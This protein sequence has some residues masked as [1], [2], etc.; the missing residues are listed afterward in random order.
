MVTVRVDHEG[1][2]ISDR[3]EKIR[4]VQQLNLI[5]G[6]DERQNAKRDIAEA[7]T[8]QFAT[9]AQ[10]MMILESRGYVLREA[11]GKFK[12]I[13][14][15]KEL[16]EI[17]VNLAEEKLSGDRQN[18]ERIAQLK[19]LFYKYAASHSTGL[20][21]SRNGFTSDFA[22]ALK[23]KF[24]I[25]LLFHASSDKPVYG[26][27]IIDHSGKQVLKGSQVIPLMELL[28][29]QCN[30]VIDEGI[31]AGDTSADMMGNP[32]EEQIAYYHALLKA[33][34]YNYPDFIQGLHHQGLTIFRNGENFSLHDPGM[35]TSVPLEDV[36]GEKEYHLVMRHFTESEESREAYH[37]R[38]HLREFNLASD[39]DDEAIHGRNR[40]RVK[41]ART[42]SR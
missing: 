22:I 40:R 11:D 16:S 37:H 33:A 17:Q 32:G 14:F 36:A 6:I 9:K 21:K 18:E 23:E 4:A 42:N 25:D 27:S 5:L 41:K 3:F 34:L 38:H 2:K 30:A 19:A 12:V 20:T 8:Y 1:K 13:K 24:G 15:G 26:Y 28:A 31:T 10:F 39:I 35:Q 29:I 7:L